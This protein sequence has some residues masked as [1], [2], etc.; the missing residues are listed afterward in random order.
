MP[1]P[2]GRKL[3]A[4]AELLPTLIAEFACAGTVLKAAT[5]RMAAAKSRRG[6]KL[7]ADLPDRF[8]C[9]PFSGCG[10]GR[11]GARQS[12]CVTRNQGPQIWIVFKPKRNLLLGP[13]LFVPPK[14]AV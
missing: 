5:L 8:F 12:A 14:S 1:M 3:K 9:P 11:E 13:R 10:M 4:C 6:A 2:S 7:M